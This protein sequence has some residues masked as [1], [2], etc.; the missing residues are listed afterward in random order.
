MAEL[1][2]T[3][4]NDMDS[5]RSVSR[6]AIQSA[7]AIAKPEKVA[8][9]GNSWSRRHMLEPERPEAVRPGRRGA[10]RPSVTS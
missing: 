3:V 2:E 7:L 6:R 4:Q 10:Y 5:S 9:S 8:K 1:M